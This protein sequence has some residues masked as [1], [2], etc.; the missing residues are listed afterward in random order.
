MLGGLFFS[1]NALDSWIVAFL[2]GHT[3]GEGVS[4]KVAF[5]LS[6]TAGGRSMLRPYSA[7]KHFFIGHIYFDTSSPPTL[8]IYN[9]VESIGLIVNEC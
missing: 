6:Q 9:Y 7:H 1:L 8:I 4:K 2:L 3:A 5:L